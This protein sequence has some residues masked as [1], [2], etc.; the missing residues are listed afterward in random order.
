MKAGLEIHQQLAVGK[1]FCA[2]PAELSEEVL[3]SFDRSLRASSGENRVVDPAAALQASRGLV[4]RYEVVP[5][6]CLVDMDEEPPSPLNPDAL[7]TALTMALLLDAT[8]V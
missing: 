4:Y 2:C 3:G 6:S 7:D 5:P 8:P 1:L